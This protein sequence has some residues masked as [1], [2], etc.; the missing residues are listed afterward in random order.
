MNTFVCLCGKNLNT[1]PDVTS[2]QPSSSKLSQ[3]ERQ[4][5]FFNGASAQFSAALEGIPSLTPKRHWE[6]SGLESD[7]IVLMGRGVLR[8]W[9]SEQSH[10]PKS[11]FRKFESSYL[12]HGLDFLKTLRGQFSLVV[13]DKQA[14]ELN[15]LRDPVGYYP[16]YYAAVPGG[17]AVSSHFKP[18]K[19]TLPE[20]LTLS[21]LSMVLF[22]RFGYIPAPYT[23]N[24]EISRLMPGNYLQSTPE[25][26]IEISRYY[27]VP[28]II[29]VQRDIKEYV[30]E[31]R[32]LMKTIVADFLNGESRPGLFLSGGMDSTVVAGILNE[33]MGDQLKA[34]SFG[35]DVPHP[36][37]DF[38]RDLPFARLCAESLRIPF[39]E[40]IID[41]TFDV[42][43][44]MEKV[45][46]GADL[47][48][49]SPNVIT[50]TYLAE[51]MKREGLTSIFT[52]SAVT[53][54]FGIYP[55]PYLQKKIDL[56]ARPEEGFLRL[57][58]RFLQLEDIHALLPET[59]CISN[60]QV[61]DA[62]SGYFQPVDGEPPEDN[63]ERGLKMLMLSEKMIPVHLLIEDALKIPFKIPFYDERVWELGARMPRPMKSMEGG[64]G[65]KP[66]LRMAFED[67]IPE[68][69][70]TRKKAGYPS[71]YWN[72]G[73]ISALQRRLFSEVTF[74]RLPFMNREVL[75]DI[76][77]REKPTNRKSTGKKAW[78]LSIFILWYLSNI[79]D[80][81]VG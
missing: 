4:N 67:V 66:V 40:C 74:K 54:G 50:K 9:F 12:E 75:L 24:E 14:G 3:Q 26:K 42:A 76:I 53:T 60:E 52:G 17:V 78:G 32:H 36:R 51:M 7:N 43:E 15:A 33:Q 30:E 55:L 11:F 49:L 16:L 1:K 79:E 58:A 39:A 63:F 13:F 22:M 5:F 59:A 48:Q 73:E 61:M 71:Y 44:L 27:S 25:R 45:V 19:Q 23:I 34:Y 18:L 6:L 21:T 65:M 46:R 70:I 29:P 47:L 69:V 8:N 37:V 35:V 81:K 31:S 41:K 57:G 20:R 68:A 64:M 80:R 38:L 62:I 56:S 2:N 28:P 10:S 77:E 72:K